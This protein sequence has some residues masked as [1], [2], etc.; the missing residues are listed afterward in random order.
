MEGFNRLLGEMML[1][2]VGQSQQILW[3]LKK[4]MQNYDEVKTLKKTNVCSL[5]QESLENV[6]KEVQD[7]KKN[8]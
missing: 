8:V 5:C 2:N 6:V 1:G 4:S 7:V 3:A